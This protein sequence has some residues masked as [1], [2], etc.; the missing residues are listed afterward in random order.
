MALAFLGYTLPEGQMSLWGATVITNILQTIP[1]VGYK[2][3]NLVWGNFAVSVST[4]KRF[5]DF[6]YLLPFGILALAAAHLITLHS[7]SGSSPLGQSFSG[8]K[9]KFH[10]YFTLKDV[11]GFLVFGLLLFYVCAF[12]PNALN[13]ADNYIEANPLVTPKS[14]VPEWYFLP[15]YSILRA[16]P[17][18]SLG[19]LAFL[20]SILVLFPLSLDNTFTTSSRFKPFSKFNFSFI[21][22]VTSLLTSLGSRHVGIP[23][24]SLSVVLVYLY[25]SYF[26][27]IPTVSGL[28]HNTLL[29]FNKRG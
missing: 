10:P 20:M 4:T 5:F 29:F 9:L 17:D 22:L 19:V 14:I 27:I 11:L 13:H 6:H 23:Y 7:T 28:F 8:D 16:V 15:F 1:V 12:L 24:T 25:F 3:T 26:L 21:V 18:K 2:L